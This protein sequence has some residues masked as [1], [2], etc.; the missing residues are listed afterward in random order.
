MLNK[1]KQTYDE[2]VCTCRYIYQQG[3]M[4]S[5]YNQSIGEN[6]EENKKIAQNMSS[7]LCEKSIDYC[8]KNTFKKLQ[9]DVVLGKHPITCLEF[10]FPC[11]N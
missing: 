1:S 9:N 10:L 7:K 4:D 3:L 5:L 2:Y 8:F 11:V 6:V